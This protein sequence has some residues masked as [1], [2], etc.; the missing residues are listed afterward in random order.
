MTKRPNSARCFDEAKKLMPGGVSS[1][2]RAFGG[3]GGIPPF[4]SRARGSH[5][6][7]VDGNE[8][9]DYV[10]SF[11]P[12][13]LGHAHPK[14]I[15]ALHEA[16][17]LGTSFGAPT[18]LET[19][20]AAMISDAIPSIEMVRFVNS[21]T[22]A[23]MSALR[24]A[25]G[26]TGRPKVIKFEGCY[27]GHADSLLVK[28]GSGAATCGVPTSAGVTENVAADTLVAGYNDLEGVKKIFEKEAGNLAC[29]IVEPVAGNM[30]C[31]LPTEGFLSGLRSL[32]DRS[33][34][35][36]IIDEVM[37]GFRVAFGGAQELYKIRP[38]ITCLGKIV[39]G[40]LPVGA[41]GGPRKLMEKMA[42]LGPVY[43]AGTLSGNPLAMTAGIKTLELLSVPGTYEKLETTSVTL[44]SGISEVLNGRKITH[45]TNRA[46]SMFSVFFNGHEVRNFTGAST[47]DGEKFRRMFH[48]LL[49]HGI[50][51]APSAFE[52]AFVSLAHSDDDV[53]RTVEV[54]GEWASGE[55]RLSF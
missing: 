29:V 39:G 45:Q 19:R 43:Q 2:V 23:A 7:D 53:R 35:L 40:G 34:A 24:L 26:A 9:I 5:I 1:P 15:A 51:I 6:W 42:P 54:I 3:V 37:T 14:V 36:L 13:I 16:I 46:G 44:C 32:C 55:T 33:G 17:E 30:G 50:Y 48:F 11:G 52:S 38:D 4:I 28:A 47:S 41:Y 18:D 22:E 8:Y 12:A 31:V 10:G 20:L 27:H 49:D 25:R 21:G